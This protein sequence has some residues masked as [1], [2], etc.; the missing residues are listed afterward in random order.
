MPELHLC[1][2]CRRP[3]REDTEDYVIDN[4]HETVESRWRYVHVECHEKSLGPGPG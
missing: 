3:I 1:A 2:I 4:K